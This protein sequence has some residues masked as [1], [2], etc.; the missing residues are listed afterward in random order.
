[1]MVT[2]MR[3][4]SGMWVIVGRFKNRS[5]IW[6]KNLIRQLC[7]IMMLLRRRETVRFKV[8]SSGFELEK[9]INEEISY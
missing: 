6:D 5:I 1:M 7:R 8:S 4:G 2:T 3:E 9:L